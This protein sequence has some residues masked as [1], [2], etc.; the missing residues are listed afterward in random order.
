MGINES[1]LVMIR[2]G[3]MGEQEEEEISMEGAY[4][5]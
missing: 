4:P 3:K 2:G 5:G 1:M